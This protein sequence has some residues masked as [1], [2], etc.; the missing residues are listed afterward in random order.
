[1]GTPLPPNET[2]N[3]CTICWGPGK[4][5]ESIPQPRWIWAQVM[6]IQPGENWDPA[7]E[8][9]MLTPHVL[10]QQD[11][12]CFYVIDDGAFTFVLTFQPLFSNLRVNHIATNTKAFDAITAPRCSLNF[13][14]IRETPGG[15]YG[16][17]GTAKTS[18]DGNF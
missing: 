8:Q 1:M 14:D 6:D 18:F 10:V 2:D 12:P 17:G 7:L 9:L 11:F 13:D 15:T 16:F 5:F 4:T 3:I